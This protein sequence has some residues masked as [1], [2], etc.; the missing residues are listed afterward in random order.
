MI[1]EFH[2]AAAAELEAAVKDALTFGRGVGL[3]LRLETARVMLLLSSTPGIGTPCG[4]V[5]RRF[6]LNGFPFSIVY[7]LDASVLRI[8]AFAHKRRR[9]GYW[10]QRR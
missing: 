1:V 2:P 6:S 4:S 10:E 3:R 8:V 9:P 7:R 5:Y